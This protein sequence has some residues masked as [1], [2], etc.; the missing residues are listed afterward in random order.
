MAKNKA[1]K[2]PLFVHLDTN[3]VTG[4]VRDDIAREYVREERLRGNRI[5][6][7]PSII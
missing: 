6:L 7:S 2:E 1:R 3:I 5:L 4:L